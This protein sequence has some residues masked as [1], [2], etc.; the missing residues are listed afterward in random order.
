MSH[1]AAELQ[2]AQINAFLNANLNEKRLAPELS[3]MSFVGCANAGEMSVDQKLRDRHAVFMGEQNVIFIL[4][5][6][7][8]EILSAD[9][10]GSATVKAWQKLLYISFL[11]CLLPIEFYVKILVTT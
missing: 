8:L 5:P 4:T 1:P 9:T 6:I 11:P 7:I 2:R 10:W 3:V